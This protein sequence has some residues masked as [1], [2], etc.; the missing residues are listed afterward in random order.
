MK[1]Y[2]NQVKDDQWF[3]HSPSPPKGTI[4][5]IWRHFW[6]HNAGTGVNVL[7]SSGQRPEKLHRIAPHKENKPVQNINSVRIER[8]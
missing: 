3:I 1:I 7:S 2:Q 4:D 5:N 8:L 6:C